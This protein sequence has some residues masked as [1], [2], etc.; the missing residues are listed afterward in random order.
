MLKALGPNGRTHRISVMVAS[1]IKFAFQTNPDFTTSAKP[2]FE[3]GDIAKV[4][5]MLYPTVSELF[6]DAG[7]SW[8][9]ESRNGIPYDVLKESIQVFWRWND[10]P[11]E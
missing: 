9:R 3:S 11:W 6:K 8:L 4:E 7:I 10:M 2:V 5:A 1:M